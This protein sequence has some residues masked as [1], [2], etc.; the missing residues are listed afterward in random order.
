MPFPGKLL[1]MKS[2]ACRV[3]SPIPKHFERTLCRQTSEV[4]SKF[5][6]STRRV[7]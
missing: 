1:I 3:G 2:V 7:P 5:R 6:F 4:F